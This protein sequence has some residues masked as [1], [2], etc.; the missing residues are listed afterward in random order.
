MVFGNE[1]SQ[2]MYGPGK[3]TIPAKDMMLVFQSG[4]KHIS[5]LDM[6]MAL[7][8]MYMN[9]GNGIRKPTYGHRKP[10]SPEIQDMKL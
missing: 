8:V 1:T 6:I 5:E 4:I 9:F 10:A 3:Q 7:K 2:Q